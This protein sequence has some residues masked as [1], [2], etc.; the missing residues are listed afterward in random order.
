M[1]DQVKLRKVKLDYIKI[2]YVK[3]DNNIKKGESV[4]LNEVL[5]LLVNLHYAGSY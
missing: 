1:L 2:V 3:P 4:N 5:I